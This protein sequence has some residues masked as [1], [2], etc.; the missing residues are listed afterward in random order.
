MLDAA[1]KY[2][3]VFELLAQIDKDFQE[4]FI[5]EQRKEFVL[6]TDADI[7]DAIASNVVI[8]DVF[9]DIEEEEE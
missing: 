9:E 7:E 8:E 3:K 6:P 5:F 1:E 4:R 2:E